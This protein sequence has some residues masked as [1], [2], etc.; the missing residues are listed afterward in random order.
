MRRSFFSRDN[1]ENFIKFCR[2]LGVHENLLFES[3]DLVLHN[4]P[5]NVI[6][7]LL[8]VARIATRYGIEPPGLVQLEKEIAEEEQRNQSADSGLSS[9]L[10][11]QFQ[12]STPPRK[13]DKLRHS[14]SASAISSYTDSVWSTGPH[15][16]LVPQSTAGGDNHK[17]LNSITASGASDGVPSDNTEDEWSR[18]SGEDPDADVDES[19]ML[20]GGG[21]TLTE[22]D[23]KVQQATRL[24]QKNCNCAN[25]K[26]SKLR[27]RKV[28]EGRYNIA[29]RNVFVRVN[30]IN[31]KN[32]NYF[33]TIIF[34][35]TNCILFFSY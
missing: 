24:M 15:M 26:C 12:A 28:G 25:G 32:K 20:R 33:Q 6:L 34:N 35:F 8:E 27:V 21:D 13:H 11:W 23:R 4:Q 17:H 29:G 9:M 1:M 22:L 31:K 3:D 2:S 7:C 14:N 19:D 30:I 10:S 16:L 18:G 5:R